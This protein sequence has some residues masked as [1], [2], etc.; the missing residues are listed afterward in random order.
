MVERVEVGDVR[1]RRRWSVEEKLRI[2]AECDQPGACPAEVARRYDL[3]MGLLYTWQRMSERRVPRSATE[4]LALLP[5]QHRHDGGQRLG[6]DA[7]VHLQLDQPTRALN[8]CFW[9]APRVGERPTRGQTGQAVSGEGAPNAYASGEY[10][11]GRL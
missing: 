3:S 8:G 2:L 9:V 7:G 4:P 5:L 1:R 6:V 11:G 10:R